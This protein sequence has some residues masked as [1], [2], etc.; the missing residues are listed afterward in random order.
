MLLMQNI[1]CHKISVGYSIMQIFFFVS[2]YKLNVKYREEG[3][4]E[5]KVIF[6]GSSVSELLALLTLFLVQD[7]LSA[8]KH[9][10]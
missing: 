1:P 10:S 4:E 6:Q 5:G 2:A 8:V 7:Q 3:R 9:L